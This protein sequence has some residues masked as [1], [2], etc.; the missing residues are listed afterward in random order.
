MVAEQFQTG[1]LMELYIHIPFCVKKCDYCDFLSFPMGRC[2]GE[3]KQVN[4]YVEALCRELGEISGFPDFDGIDTVFMGGGT[5]SLLSDKQTE[6]ILRAVWEVLKAHPQKV[7]C[8][9]AV[10]ADAEANRKE[11]VEFTVECNP[12]TLTEEKLRLYKKYGVNRLSIGLQSADDRELKL[13]GRIHSYEEFERNFRLARR[14]GFSNINVDLISAIPGQSVESW[15]NTLRKVVMLGPEHISAYSLII[16]EGTPFYE[17]FGEEDG[18]ED[19]TRLPSEDDE[20]EMYRATREFLAEYGYHRYEISNYAREGFECRHNLGYWT[21]EEYIACGL[22]AS[23]YL[24]KD[25]FDM[26]CGG[27]GV[28]A[29]VAVEKNKETGYV[30]FK[31]TDDVASYISDSTSPAHLFVDETLD[32][33]GQMAEF[34]ILSLRLVKGIDILRFR[35]LFGMDFMDEYGFIVEK[36]EGL[37]LLKH[38]QDRIFLTE[39]GF[40]VSNRIMAE[41]L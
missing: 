5:P 36:Y 28:N 24:K 17:K 34:C 6:Q 2:T 35:Q 12:G 29:E 13:L 33:A 20:R 22:G 21:G 39:D 27:H 32:A 8:G 41:F 15:K 14:L 11:P 4:E 1:R 19:E 3:N 37:G 26:Y 40:D 16:E 9:R 25:R 31:N 23:S 10:V 30:R 38:E 18:I 7:N